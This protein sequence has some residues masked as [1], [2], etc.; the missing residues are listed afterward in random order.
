MMQVV[1][2]GLACTSV[3]RLNLITGNFLLRHHLNTEKPQ[4]SDFPLQPVP[5][6]CGAIHRRLVQYTLFDNLW[7]SEW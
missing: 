5:D 2:N 4:K 1:H 7:S 3:G 6:P